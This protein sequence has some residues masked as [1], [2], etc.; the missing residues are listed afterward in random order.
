MARR[1]KRKKSGLKAATPI[2][3]EESL[4]PSRP[5]SRPALIA[6]LLV[7]LL[8]GSGIYF[9]SMVDEPTAVEYGINAEFLTNNHSTEPGYKTDFILIIHNIGSITDTFDITVKSNNGGFSNILI[10]DDYRSVVL[11]K[12]QRKTI[13]ISVETSSSSTGNK[14]AYLEIRSQ[15]DK[16]KY[17]DAK[18]NVDTD[19]KFGNQTV[20]GDS[21]KVHYAGILASDAR[22]FDASMESVWD[23]YKISNHYSQLGSQPVTENGR[24]IEPLD[25]VNSG[26][27][28]VNSPSDNCEGSAKMIAGFDA[29][30]IGMYE[31]QTLAVR[32]PAKDAYGESGTHALGGQDLIFLI[33][34]VSIVP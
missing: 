8:I 33:E 19:Y 16:E 10:E 2:H 12:D 29:K 15:G 20:I 22:L 18:I 13:L 4:K 28:D 24:H 34:I 14:F 9:T 32:I 21:V 6:L 11:G 1:I 30:I 3:R 23:S 7:I 5:D 27:N 26:C 31:G 25:A 17:A